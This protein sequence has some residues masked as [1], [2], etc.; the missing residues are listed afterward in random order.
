MH[1]EDNE[2]KEKRKGIN[3]S[4]GLLSY[5]KP[6]DITNPTDKEEAMCMCKLCLNFCLKFDA[7]MTHS[8]NFNGPHFDSISSYY[9]S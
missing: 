9:M 6:F 1:W 2:Y 7:L 5:L 8:K 4:T 3:I